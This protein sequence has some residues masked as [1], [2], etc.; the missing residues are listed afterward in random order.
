MMM[1]VTIMLTAKTHI[2]LNAILDAVLKTIHQHLTTN[3]SSG[4]TQ[5]AHR[6]FTIPTLQETTLLALRWHACRSRHNTSQIR[7][8]TVAIL[9]PYRSHRHAGWTA[10]DHRLLTNH[11]LRLIATLSILLLWILLLWI[12]LL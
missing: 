12:L 2:T 4:T 9:R 7:T 3:H 5:Q 1:V 8:T 10:Q 11:R 6:H